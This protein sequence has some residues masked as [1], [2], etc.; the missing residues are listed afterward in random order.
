[1]V[2]VILDADVSGLGTKGVVVSVKPSYAENVILAQKL[3]SIATPADLERIAAEAA[4]AAAAA[5]AAKKKA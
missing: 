2:P 1:M 3:G 4:A 5:A